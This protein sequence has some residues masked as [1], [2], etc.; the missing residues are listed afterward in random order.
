MASGVPFPFDPKI[1]VFALP[2]WGVGGDFFD[3]EICIFGAHIAANTGGR[4]AHGQ[5]VRPSRA[6]D[7]IEP[8]IF[9]Q[10]LDIWQTHHRPHRNRNCRQL[11]ICARRCIGILYSF[12]GVIDRI[13]RRGNFS[14]LNEDDDDDDDE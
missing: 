2:R 6:D 9:G 14:K 4:S 8:T 7:F 11:I 1:D 10:I 5:I 13:A 3:F 12:N